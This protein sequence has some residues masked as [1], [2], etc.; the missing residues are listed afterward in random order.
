MGDARP[1]LG[2]A[3]LFCACVLLTLGISHQLDIIV[4]SI[5]LEDQ[6][7]WDLHNT[8][9]SAPE[10]FA[11]VYCMELGLNGDFKCVFP[12]AVCAFPL[13]ER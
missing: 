2:P 11:E 5:R 7:E 3:S 8:D 6:F 12:F 4:G 13:T 9:G 10:R 1:S